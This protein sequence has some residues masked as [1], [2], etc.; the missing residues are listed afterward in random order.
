LVTGDYEPHSDSLLIRYSKAGKSRSIILSRE[1]CDFFARLCAGRAPGDPMLTKADGT[2]WR[3][4][5]QDR[6][7]KRVCK[8]AGV[9]YAGF[10]ALRHSYAT[11]ALEADIPMHVIAQNLGHADISML[12]RHYAHITDKH[13]RSEIQGKMTP[14]NLDDSNVV[15]LV[16][17]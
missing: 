14:L 1:A 4:G 3:S 16:R 17:R 9:N 15:A 12:Q 13:R 6:P 5:D 11:A 8:T 10:H 7:M 2:P